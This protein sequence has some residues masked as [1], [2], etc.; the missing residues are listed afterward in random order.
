MS[1]SNEVISSERG[2]LSEEKQETKRNRTSVQYFC[3][4]IGSFVSF[5]L[6]HTIIII[7]KPK[8]AFK[9]LLDQV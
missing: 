4:I 7:Q 2:W 3:N 6:H 8:L 1:I 9:H 5:K